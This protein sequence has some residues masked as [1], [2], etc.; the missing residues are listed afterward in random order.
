L[1][2]RGRRRIWTLPG[3]RISP[4]LWVRCVEWAS[5]WWK[6]KKKMEFRVRSQFFLVF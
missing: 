3:R 2:W 1:E 5:C 6:S 4:C